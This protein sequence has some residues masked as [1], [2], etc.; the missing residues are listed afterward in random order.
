MRV[1]KTGVAIPESL[2]KE[3]DSLMKSLGYSSRS[4]A[5]AESVRMFVTFNKWV[6]Y[7]GEVV[8]AI[9][10]VYNHKRHGIDEEL[11]DIQ[12]E[13]LGTILS[14]LHIHLSEEYCL[15]VVTVR[16]DVSKVKDLYSK[17]VKLRGVI[18]VQPAVFSYKELS[19][20]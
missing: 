10:I 7:K 2:V 1:V 12:H 17:I 9:L 18:H 15:Q 4:K 11:T 6:S 13:F 3:L 20:K 5:I 8:G 19:T 14:S 16:G